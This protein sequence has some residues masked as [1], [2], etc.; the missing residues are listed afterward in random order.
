MRKYSFV[1][2]AP[3]IIRTTK[4]LGNAVVRVFGP[5]KIGLVVIKHFVLIPP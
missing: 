5:Q 2:L 1:F 4:I 3:K